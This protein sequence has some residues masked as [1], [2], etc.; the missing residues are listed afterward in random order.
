V[1]EQHPA[2]GGR[3]IRA[4]LRRKARADPL[5]AEAEAIPAASTC[6]AIIKR[7]GL[8]SREESGLHVS[9]EGF[10][11]EAPNQLWQMTFTG[12]FPLVGEG[13]CHALTIVDDHSRFALTLQACEDE[14]RETVKRRLTAVFR[15]YGLSRT[16][17]VKTACPTTL[18]TQGKGE[19]F[20][21]GPKK[22][23]LEEQLVLSGRV[24]A[25]PR[26]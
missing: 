26:R 21:R 15:R 22:Q 9:S 14:Q 12:H 16:S 13:R 6:R 11:K 5:P 17:C 18:E 4:R 3:K 24:C 23:T 1:W 25:I 2:W 7:R 20:H 19:R 8:V 10:E